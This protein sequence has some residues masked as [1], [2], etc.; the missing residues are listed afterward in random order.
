MTKQVR[1][2]VE[3]NTDGTDKTE[4]GTAYVD[5]IPNGSLM[6]DMTIT[7]PNMIKLLGGNQLKGIIPRGLHFSQSEWKEED[8]VSEAD[9]A[10][11]ERTLKEISSHLRELVKVQAA[12]NENIVTMARDFKSFVASFDTVTMVDAGQLQLRDPAVDDVLGE[13]ESRRQRPDLF[14]DDKEPDASE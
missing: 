4:I 8:V 10:R 3:N 9:T 11:I 13:D 7:H 12:L 5:W 14:D 2:V 6:V 1:L